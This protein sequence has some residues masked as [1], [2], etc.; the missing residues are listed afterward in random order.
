MIKNNNIDNYIKNII[1]YN[2]ILISTNDQ[3]TNVDNFIS[4]IKKYLF[5][6]NI[7][8]IVN[9]DDLNVINNI[10]P[11]VIR[12]NT[13][14]NK[15]I[16]DDSFIISYKDVFNFDTPNIYFKFLIKTKYNVVQQEP[17]CSRFLLY[18]SDL[19]L[20]VNNDIIKIFK[21]RISSKHFLDG[22]NIND[23]NRY[24]V[25]NQIKNNISL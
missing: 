20:C 9:D 11:K 18:N 21:N 22:K 3:N 23:I 10:N 13:I 19:I 25:I 17:L 24:L 16:N 8:F 12:L 7:S 1:S 14:I 15:K 2:R 4:I 6:N 5:K